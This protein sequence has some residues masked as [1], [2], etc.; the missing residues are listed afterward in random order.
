MVE[1]NWLALGVEADKRIARCEDV[2]AVE[3]A[4]MRQ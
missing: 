1:V 3:P 4:R 2:V